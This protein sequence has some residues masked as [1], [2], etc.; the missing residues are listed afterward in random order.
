MERTGAEAQV[1]AGIEVILVIQR[2]DNGRI[3]NGCPELCL[4]YRRYGTGR[5]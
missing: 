3:R 5:T 2:R 1:G 4:P